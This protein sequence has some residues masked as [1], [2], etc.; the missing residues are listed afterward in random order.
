[1]KKLLV[2][3]FMIFTCANINILRAETINMQWLNE[4]GTVYDTTSCTAGGDVILPTA[5]T[6]RGYTFMGWVSFTPIEYLESTGTQYINTG[7][8]FSGPNARVILR[9]EPTN[10]NH[11]GRHTYAGAQP[12]W[13]FIANNVAPGKLGVYHGSLNATQWSQADISVNTIYTLDM[14]QEGNTFSYKINNIENSAYTTISYTSSPYI[15]FGTSIGSA[16]AEFSQMRL[17]YAKIYDNGV[18]IR[19]FIPGL[20]QNGVPCMYDNVSRQYFYNSGTGDFIAG[21]VAHE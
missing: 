9:F 18:L 13:T 14:V 16:Y 1:M 12:G 20:D 2:F 8:V 21:P 5:P 3:L 7:V 19:D 6:K 4:D 11:Y 15:L 10:V 17:Y